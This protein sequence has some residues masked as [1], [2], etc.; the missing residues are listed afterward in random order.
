MMNLDF[1]LPT[2]YV[3]DVSRLVLGEENVPRQSP[4]KREVLQWRLFALLNLISTGKI[5]EKPLEMLF[6]R[7]DLNS[8]NTEQLFDFAVILADLYEQYIVYRP[9]WLKDWENGNNPHT[10]TDANNYHAEWQKVI[11]KLLVN[12]SQNTPF[13]LQ[14]YMLQQR[15]EQKLAASSAKLPKHLYLF[16][17]GSLPPQFMHFFFNLSASID[18]HFLVLN[19]SQI[20]WG[21]ALTDKQITIFEQ[22]SSFSDIKTEFDINPLLRNFGQQGKEFIDAILQKEHIQI[23][24]FE[25]I[26]SPTRS[27]LQSIQQDIL[28]G[29]RCR[30]IEIDDSV[31]F[32]ACHS[33]VRELQVLKERLLHALHNDNELQLDE[34]LVLTPNIEDYAPFIETIFSH[35]DNPALHL[36]VSISDRK[37]IESDPEVKSFLCVLSLVNSRFEVEEVFAPLSSDELKRSF[38]FQSDDITLVQQWLRTAAVSWGK[39]ASHKQSVVDAENVNEKHTWKSAIQRIVIGM[40]N[41]Q[42]RFVADSVALSD[43]VEGQQQKVLGSFIHYL[44]WLI[45]LEQSAKEVNSIDSYAMLVTRIAQQYRHS[46]HKRKTLGISLIEESMTRFTDTFLLSQENIS[47]SFRSI[48]SAFQQSLSLPETKAKYLLGKITFCSMIPMRSVPFKVIAIL[49]LNQDSFP[50]KSIKSELNLMDKTPRRK[51]DRSRKNDDRYLFLEAILS[52][53]RSLHLS[54]QDRNIK[55]NSDRSPS[56]V[57]SELINFIENGTSPL[58]ISI[59]SHPLY[60]FDASNY[61]VTPENTPSIDNQPTGYQSKLPATSPNYDDAWFKIATTLSSQSDESL[62]TPINKPFKPPQFVNKQHFDLTD[63]TDFYLNPLRGIMRECYAVKYPVFFDDSYEQ[64]FSMTNADKRKLRRTLFE[65]NKQEVSET[66]FNAYKQQFVES[67]DYADLTSMDIYFECQKDLMCEL[68]QYSKPHKTLSDTLHIADSDIR[69]NVDIDK[70]GRVVMYSLDDTVGFR[71]LV[72]LRFATLLCANC[73]IP[74]ETSDV[75]GIMYFAR[76]NIKTPTIKQVEI[77]LNVETCVTQITKLIDTYNSLVSHPR[78]LHPIVAQ[79]LFSLI[80]EHGKDAEQVQAYWNK[81]SQPR[82]EVNRVG[83]ANDQHYQFL[84]PSHPKFDEEAYQ[85]YK[86]TYFTILDGMR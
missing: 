81:L 56:S 28:E 24:A 31:M 62:K 29:T 65:L 5:K 19:P 1:P 57:L 13:S 2:R 32:H 17:I 37:P 73:L 63:L 3:W 6:K 79:D 61:T 75:S 48:H 78:L 49:G 7:F 10:L 54:Y 82:D 60:P 20:Y 14:P 27:L 23:D 26:D 22:R 58:K 33:A 42:Q 46:S 74:N 69:F 72:R 11:W 16:A 59:N 47:L 21:D 53:R 77:T 44:D 85:H 52:A 38:D 51:G 39:D 8:D 50:R 70:E 41:P 35:P 40:C 67:G 36:P 45:Q 34:I 12:S 55:D 43:V 83:M 68:Y 66:T 64:P 84:F 80:T 30:A 25:S 4:F 71:D 9:D 86:N 18:V 76:D 15:A